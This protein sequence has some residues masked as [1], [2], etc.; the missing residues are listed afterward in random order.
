M[1]K[2]NFILCGHRALNDISSA[3]HGMS[4]RAPVS[5]WELASRWA[6]H[7]EGRLVCQIQFKSSINVFSQSKGQG[8]LG[9]VKV[10]LKCWKDRM[11]KCKGDMD[12][13]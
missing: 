8:T 4:C 2:S 3:P 9:R 1:R 7:A 5:N 6:S 11:V 13:R 12:E 10:M